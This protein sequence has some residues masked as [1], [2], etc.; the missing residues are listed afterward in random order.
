MKLALVLRSLHCSGIGSQQGP[1][2]GVHERGDGE[3]SPSTYLLQLCLTQE[4]S[5]VEEIKVNCFMFGGFKCSDCP[6]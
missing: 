6:D 4:S 2:H 1:V 3:N 5:P